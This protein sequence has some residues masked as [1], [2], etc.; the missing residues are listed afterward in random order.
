MKKIWFPIFTCGFLLS[1]LIITIIKYNNERNPVAPLLSVTAALTAAPAKDSGTAPTPSNQPT[2]STGPAD[3]AGSVL[4][5]SELN[6]NTLASLPSGTIINVSKN[7]KDIIKIAFYYEK[8]TKDLKLRMKGKSYKKD[9]T[10]P[11]ED[12]RYVR[13]LYYGFDNKT[14][15]GE[16][17]VNRQ[18]AKDVTAIF[19]DLY[20]SE[21]PIEKMVLIDDYDADDEASMADNNTS[22]FNFRRMTGSKNL[23]K[24]ALGLAIDINPLYNP[25]VKINDSGTIVSPEKA[26]EYQDRKLDNPYYITKNDVCYKAFIKRGFTWGGS[27]KSIKDYQHF[28]KSLN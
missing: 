17:V 24:H 25:Y 22:S 11:Y 21:Y 20:L 15:I 23:S 26:Y 4:S 2:P 10:V 16:L 9:C 5:H 3:N 7:K 18:I 27:W 13:V 8:I 28:E 19:K 6:K 12:L 1:I 14:H